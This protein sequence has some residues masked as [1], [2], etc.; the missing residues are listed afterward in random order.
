ME[1]HEII[2][3]W[4]LNKHH[5]AEQMGMKKGTFNNKLNPAHATQFSDKEKF[6]LIHL[7]IDLRTDLEPLEAMGF[8]DALSIIAK[9]GA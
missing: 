9:A 8:N 4:K 1:L 7:L 3:K 2:N 5:I 6:Q